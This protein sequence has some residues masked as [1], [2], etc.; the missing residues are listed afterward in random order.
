VVLVSVIA[1]G[2]FENYIAEARARAMALAGQGPHQ[3][4]CGQI[5]EMVVSSNHNESSPDTVG[6]YGAPQDPTGAFGL[7]SSIDE[8]YMD[9]LDEQIAAVA[10][11]ACDDRRPASLHATEFPV[12]PD[13]EQEIPRRFPT[14]DDFGDPAAIDP[15]VRV[16]QARDAA[17]E[18]I[19]TMM[20]LADHNQDIGHSD[21]Y[22]ESHSFSGDWPGYFHRRLEQRVGGM[23][24]FL[25]ADIGSQEDLITRPRIPDPPCDGGGNG[26]FAQVELT[27][28]RI[29]DHVADAIPGASTI[30]LGAVDGR[31]TEFCAPLENNLFRA[32]FEAGLFGERQGYTNCLPTGRVGTEVHT[33]VAVL[34][35]GE[36]L[37]FLV[38]PGEAFPALMLGGPW[39]I[40]D[41]SC[42]N[43]DN[44][45]VPAWHARARYR[46]Q[47]G[48]GDDLIGYEKPAWSFLYDTPGSFTPT[49]GCLSDPHQH[50]H[51]LEDEAVGPVASNLV[52]EHLSALLAQK[53]DPA[54]EIRLGRYVK[55]DG[56]LTD[57]YSA[58]LD[59]GAPGHFP[60]D[61]V[62]IWLAAPGS[63]SLDAEPGQADSGTIVA[64]DDVGSFG[65]RAVDDNGEFMDF[66]GVTQPP[67]PDVSTRGMLVKSGG[68]VQKRYYVDV[69][70]ALTV[71]GEL[72][73]AN[74]P[75]S[76]YPRPGGATPL[77]VALVPEFRQC[78]SP[79][80]NHAGPLAF[81]SCTGPA[82]ES[83]LL[84]TSSAGRGTGSATFAV[85]PGDPVTPANEADVKIAAAT[86]DVRNAAG[87]SDYAG[88]V[89]L[90]TT[91]RIT[92]RGN[93][94]GASATVQDTRFDVPI[95]CAT[96]ADPV[97][98][99]SC[100]IATTAN[101]LLPGFAVEG[102]RAVLSAFSFSLEDAGPDGAAIPSSGLCPP[103]CGTGD[104]SVFLRQGLFTP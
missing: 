5:D 102:N 24:M 44:P 12:P 29:A 64:L 82:L 68:S 57:A 54:A 92:D 97:L 62:A 14:A 72:G 100:A 38:N 47:A 71:T 22:E 58:P 28:N 1:Q 99:S 35:V 37:Q 81:P 16:L 31:R 13:L 20:N 63:T 104:E 55:A 93:S 40:E 15:K 48:L 74:P 39:G 23:A 3:S 45:P 46:F 6:I 87:G 83:S 70:P 91:M 21:T 56:S 36:Q 65:N 4:S 79:D 33:S 42:P 69:Y 80:S 76:A 95:D 26:C 49:D 73:A 10:V 75:P 51:A 94:G 25:A 90:S 89:I 7:N 32:A 85:L 96:N 77:R 67:G 27:G 8:Y 66:D 88:K 98:G 101:T 19:F 34:D 84:T 2:I 60:D 11:D 9:W 59:Q 86:S 52:A 43:R 18:P 30:P 103:T 78:T 53:P 17:G 61:A 41:A 50:S